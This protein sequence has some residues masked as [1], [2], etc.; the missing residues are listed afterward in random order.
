MKR[1]DEVTSYLLAHILSVRDT[2]DEQLKRQLARELCA[3]VDGWTLGEVTARTGT[4]PA[5]MSALRHGRVAG[6]SISRLVRMIGQHGYDIELALRP[7]RP[8]K[9]EWNHPSAKVVR[10]D[11][12]DRPLN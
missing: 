6:F 11:R 3:I 10:Y 1:N 2:F 7:T 12:F 9:R 4:D 8:P 5:R